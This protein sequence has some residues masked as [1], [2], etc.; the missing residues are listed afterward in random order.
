MGLREDRGQALGNMTEEPF[1]RGERAVQAKQLATRS[2]ALLAIG[3]ER[4]GR[5]VASPRASAS[6]RYLK[7]AMKPLEQARSLA[8]GAN[9]V[10]G[11]T[12]KDC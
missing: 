4:F 5:A 3:L 6:S 7:Q 10:L 1:H 2:L 11:C 9:V 12:G 8:Y